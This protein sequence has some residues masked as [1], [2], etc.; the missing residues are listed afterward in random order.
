M[1]NDEITKRRVTMTSVVAAGTNIDGEILYQKHQAIDYV[2]PDFLEA[3]VAEAQ[4]RWQM[5]EV[6]DEPD[7]GPL[8]FDGPTYVPENL[9]VP[10]AGTYYPAT[11]GSQVEKDLVKAGDRYAVATK[12]SDEPIAL[13]DL[14]EG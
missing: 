7:A 12:G 9:D 5:V 6:S 8:G 10:D 3:Y 2:R 4:K 14:Q 13:S 1:A 11:S